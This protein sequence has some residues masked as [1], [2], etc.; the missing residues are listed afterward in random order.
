MNGELGEILPTPEALNGYVS[1]SGGR[2][3]RCGR[4]NLMASVVRGRR[5]MWV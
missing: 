5:G 2:T 4:R 1:R 3:F